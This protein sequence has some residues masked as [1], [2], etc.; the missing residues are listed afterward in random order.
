MDEELEARCSL[1]YL[2][3]GGGSG[4][5]REHQR[6]GA[7]EHQERSDKDPALL[8]TLLRQRC[9]GL[10]EPVCSQEG[11]EDEPPVQEAEGPPERIPLG[12]LILR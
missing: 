10:A 7:A 5:E 11:Q 12:G 3:L 2:F 9:S 4:S 8:P 1:L 6:D